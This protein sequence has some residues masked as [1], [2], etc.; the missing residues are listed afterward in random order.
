MKV[1]TK[2]IKNVAAVYFNG[3]PVMNI[4]EIILMMSVR[5]MVKCIG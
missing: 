1:N 2:M 3:V 5:D 4:E